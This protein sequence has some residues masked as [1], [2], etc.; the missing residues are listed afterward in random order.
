MEWLCAKNRKKEINTKPNRD[1]QLAFINMMDEADKIRAQ[2]I[3][4]MYEPKKKQIQTVLFKAR[5][6]AKWRNG[7]KIYRKKLLMNKNEK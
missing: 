6:M 3:Q 4:R 5:E 7:I 1:L 2:R